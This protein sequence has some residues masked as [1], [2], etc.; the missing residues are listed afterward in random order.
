MTLP[1]SW[2]NV[3][4]IYAGD[5]YPSGAALAGKTITVEGISVILA[6]DE[7]AFP[8]KVTLVLNSDGELADGTTLPTVND[9]QHELVGVYYKITEHWTG[10]RTFT[11]FLPYSATP[12]EFNLA[13]AAPMVP[14][15][16]LV[17]TIGPKGDT[18]DTGPAGPQGETGPAGP[19]GE[20]G[21]T[22]PQGDTGATGPQGPQGDTGPQGPQGEQ[23]IQGEQGPQGDTGAT[24]PTGPTG[25]IPNV[26]S[27]T[28]A[29]TVTPTFDDDLVK[30]TAQA[31]ALALANPTGTAIPGLGI[32]IRIKDN[33]TAR[34]ISYGTQYR[35]IGVTL[36]TTT[37]V[38]KTT[39]LAG[40][41]NDT[42][43]KL[44]IVAVGTQA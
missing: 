30:I 25:R 21:A 37:V 14:P 41:W 27:V 36:P 12:E 17:S 7:A 38:G 26:Q 32:V 39:Y 42:D 24:G 2:V 9:E 31:A 40:I 23:G 11:I 44:D 1:A 16:D 5:S 18:G 33:G 29:A 20:A 15:E 34:A 3:P 10:G 19:A 22:G 6:D 13:T 35:A 4:I 43:T 8:G 28:S